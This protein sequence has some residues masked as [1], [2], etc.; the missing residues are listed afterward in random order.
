MAIAHAR[1]TRA[2]PIAAL[3][4]TILYRKMAPPVRTDGRTDGWSTDNARLNPSPLKG[5]IWLRSGLRRGRDL[6]ANL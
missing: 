6:A 4:V 5:S 3:A 2:R 1:I